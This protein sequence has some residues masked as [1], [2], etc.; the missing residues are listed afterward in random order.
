MIYI[1]DF[2]INLWL[3]LSILKGLLAWFQMTLHDKNDDDPGP[4]LQHDL[5]NNGEVRNAQ[6]CYRIPTWWHGMASM[7]N[8]VFSI[9]GK[10]DQIMLKN[11]L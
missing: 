3:F 6:H 9:S 1:W 7:R 5:I 11:C 4:D 2:Y 8:S 10:S